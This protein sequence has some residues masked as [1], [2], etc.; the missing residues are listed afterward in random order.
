LTERDRTA[1]DRLVTEITWRND[2]QAL[3]DIGL[4][5]DWVSPSQ[6]LIRYTLDEGALLLDGEQPG[7]VLPVHQEIFGLARPGADRVIIPA[8]GAAADSYR[9]LLLPGHSP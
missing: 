6:F 8:P 7:V 9:L 4:G 2:Y 5:G 3:G 1:G